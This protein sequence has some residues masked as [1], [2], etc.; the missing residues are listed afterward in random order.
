M[1][2]LGWA[3]VVVAYLAAGVVV[4][5]ALYLWG[6]EIPR[7][8]T[9]RAVVVVGWLPLL[10]LYALLVVVFALGDMPIWLVY[11]VRRRGEKR[12]KNRK[13]PDSTT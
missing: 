13:Y 12:R 4:A 9:G 8:A 10:M 11:R 7:E 2:A 5:A 3:L 6:E 1:T